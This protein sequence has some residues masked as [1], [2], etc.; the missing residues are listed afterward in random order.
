M[1]SFDI[2]KKRQ[3]YIKSNENAKTSRNML[4][5]G[6]LRDYKDPST[7]K[8][9]S[10]F[11]NFFK[12]YNELFLYREIDILF[13]DAL[14]NLLDRID[15]DKISEFFIKAYLDSKIIY[16]DL[17]ISES[18]A[19][20]FS[21]DGK[22]N[23]QV[24]LPDKYKNTNLSYAILT[25]ELT[26]YLL[27]LKE[28]K[29]DAFEFSEVLSIYFEY[30]MYQETSI[31][32]FPYF[33]NNRLVLLNDT[34]EDLRDD[35]YY[36]N[37][38]HFLGIDEENYEGVLSANNAYLESLEYVLNLIEREKQD[39]S[40]VNKSISRILQGES[41]CV[42]EAKKLDIDTTCHKQL[43]KVIKMWKC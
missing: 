6:L 2:D 21:K 9:I 33:I 13:I 38:P 25:H 22:I 28:R 31:D 3:F 1:K 11:C 15:D 19:A 18:K 12:E 7:L 39:S 35:L 16:D 26:H 8:R 27:A 14:A 24:M 42:D 5:L 17:D 23:Y 43:R 30:L 29:I 37:N 41:T 4:G 34:C 32:G 10:D 40:T 20:I 36:A